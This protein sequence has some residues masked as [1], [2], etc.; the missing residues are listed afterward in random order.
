MRPENP[1]PVLL[2]GDDTPETVFHSEWLAERLA[3]IRRER[4]SISK[5]EPP[6]SNVSLDDHR[7]NHFEHFCLTIADQAREIWI[8]DCSYEQFAREY[9][10]LCG[11]V[12]FTDLF[13]LP[14]RITKTVFL[15]SRVFPIT[16]TALIP[17]GI[18]H[19][20][21][22]KHQQLDWTELRDISVLTCDVK[23]DNSQ[24]M[25]NCWTASVQFISEAE[26]IG[27]RVLVLV[28]GRSRSVSVVLAYLVKVCDVSVEGAWEIVRRKCWHL[29]DRTLTFEK[30]LAAWE[31]SEVAL[32]SVT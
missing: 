9:G 25:L 20:I 29:V 10:F 14:H 18:T 1:S 21:V 8:L 5:Y 6:E 2:Y 26:T 3:R 4:K 23:D 16:K 15:G 19:L 28:F 30:Q 31:R 24:N 13:P 17:L 12:E 22:S 27:G 32:P 11:H 7:F